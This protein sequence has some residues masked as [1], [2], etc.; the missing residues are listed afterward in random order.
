MSSMAAPA[1][2]LGRERASL[3][4]ERLGSRATPHASQWLYASQEPLSLTFKER[5]DFPDSQGSQA[6]ELAQGEL[7]KEE[8]DSTDGQHEE[9]GHEEGSC[10]EVADGI[11]IQVDY[12]LQGSMLAGPPLALDSSHLPSHWWWVDGTLLPK[13]TEAGG[14][15]GYLFTS[16]ARE[17]RTW[18]GT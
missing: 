6:G 5:A 14:P 15:G 16:V 12:P 8:G 11:G 3:L 9:V 2:E 17:P 10:R 18:V 1:P 4:W 13:V 7:K